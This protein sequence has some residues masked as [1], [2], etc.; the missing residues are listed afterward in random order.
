MKYSSTI[1]F[2]PTYLSMGISQSATKS[3][4]F[5]WR[6]NR[7]HRLFSALS[8]PTSSPFELPYKLGAAFCACRLNCCSNCRKYSIL[9]IVMATPKSMMPLFSTTVQHY[10][11]SA[12]S[13]LLH[14]L[15]WSISHPIPIGVEISTDWHGLCHCVECRMINWMKWKKSRSA[16]GARQ[17]GDSRAKQ[18][19]LQII[20]LSHRD[21]NYAVTLN[22]IYC[23][24][25]I[26]LN[27]IATFH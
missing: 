22:A 1:Q 5:L 16:Q 12:C 3:N 10:C 23:E 17:G 27:F 2:S 20:K 19:I 11:K 13:T 18:L 26:F 7:K 4:R 6:F 14:F 25:Y 15:L 24:N 8:L 9:N 21:L